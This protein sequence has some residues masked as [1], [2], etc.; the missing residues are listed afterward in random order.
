MSLA[1]RESG[2]CETAPVESFCLARP[3]TFRELSE[4]PRGATSG[5]LHECERQ[6][7]RWSWDGIGASHGLSTVVAN[8]SCASAALSTSRPRLDPRLAWQ[9]LGERPGP[10]ACAF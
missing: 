6:P 1:L 7:S 9:S 3:R 4:T 2:D 5:G 8:D 10:C